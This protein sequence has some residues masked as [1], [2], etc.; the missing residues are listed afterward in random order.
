MQWREE[1]HNFVLA[2]IVRHSTQMN[3]VRTVAATASIVVHVVPT[4]VAHVV[5]HKAIIRVIR[6]AA[7]EVVETAKVA[8]E[9]APTLVV[10]AVW[11]ASAA[12]AIVRVSTRVPIAFEILKVIRNEYCA[13]IELSNIKPDEKLLSF[14]KLLFPP[15][16]LSLKLLPPPKLFPRLVFRHGAS[17]LLLLPPLLLLFDCDH[18]VSGYGRSRKKHD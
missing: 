17:L 16:K 1:L 13:V 6:T 18:G 14:L 8:I 11:I 10:T 3:G 9:R 7:I 15:P 5:V 12:K 4:I 2:A